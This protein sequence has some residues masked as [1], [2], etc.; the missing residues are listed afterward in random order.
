VPEVRTQAPATRVDLACEKCQCI[1]RFEGRIF[2]GEYMHAC[3]GCGHTQGEDQI[4]P[5]WEAPDHGWGPM[6]EKG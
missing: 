4:Y 5:R 3:S 1:M 6:R 2:H